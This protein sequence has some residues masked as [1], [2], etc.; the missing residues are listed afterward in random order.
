MENAMNSHLNEQTHVVLDHG[1]GAKLSHDLLAMITTELGEAHAGKMEDSAILPVDGEQIAMT[2]DSFVVDPVFFGNG[3][4]GKI[5]V[6][7]TV[8]DIAVSGAHPY[9]ITLGLILEE[10]LPL[11]DLR[12]ILRSIC[13]TA[14]AAN[15][16]IVAGD[17][18]VVKAGECDK[19][20]I[21]TSG[22]GVFK[23]PPLSMS[24]VKVG[25]KIILNGWIGNH[26]VHLLSVREG[27]GFENRVLS[28]CAPLNGL[29]DKVLTRH[30]GAVRS[31]RDITRG[32]LAAVLQEYADTLGRTIHIDHERLPLQPEMSMAADMLGVNPLHLANEGCVGL[33]VDP[34][35]ADKIV[36][37]LKSDEFGREARII[38]EVT[39]D[40]AGN[41]TMARNASVSVVEELQGA[42]LPRLC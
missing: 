26:A 10:G 16:K 22:V 34:N 20:F 4:I 42:E 11:D 5:A 25:D 8:N 9:Y 1:T 24:D 6:C 23:R 18:K 31:A 12:R 39:E 15:V 29:V 40:R 3:D 14:V 17:T 27:L 33:F 13:R 32:G 30:P 36:E 41:L 28:D 38:G 2:T 21:N 19:I 37:T 7:G 35:E